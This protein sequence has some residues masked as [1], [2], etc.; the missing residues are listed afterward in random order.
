MH[1]HDPA[2]LKSRV[3]LAR[4]RWTAPPASADERPLFGLRLSLVERVR[5]EIAAGVYGTPEKWELALER[6]FD[7]VER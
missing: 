4:A 2:R 6:L 1:R 5:R 3:H 7:E